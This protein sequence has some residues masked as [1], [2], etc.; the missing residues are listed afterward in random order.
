MALMNR[1][2]FLGLAIVGL[3]LVPGVSFGDEPKK[4]ASSTSNLEEETLKEFAELYVSKFLPAQKDP[5]ATNILYPGSGSDLQ[6]LHLGL[7]LLKNSPMERVRYVYTEIG[8]AVDKE[9]TVSWYNH[10]EDLLSAF[11]QELA[12]FVSRGLLT[13]P[14]RKILAEHPWRVP[15]IPQSTVIEYSFM[16]PVG[17][18]KKELSLVL[19][20]N[21]FE[22]RPELTDSEKEYFSSE[23]LAKV[24]ANYWP[25]KP[26]AGAI[27]PKYARD[28][29][30]SAAD[31]ILSHQCGDF[32]LLMF[33]YLRALLNP[34][35]EKK[36][37]IILTEHPEKNYALTKPPI[38][39]NCGV[40]FL[41]HN[42]YGYV[43]GEGKVGAV[44]FTPNYTR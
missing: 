17:S 41:K 40:E 14:Q 27:Y 5:R 6:Q 13:N 12:P 29:Q 19:S 20:Y 3:G 24:R 42:H 37:K 36:Q 33:D 32:D 22:E 25:V 2:H 10:S 8:E 38:G 35:T 30:F 7:S 18:G 16:V 15:N 4:N 28:D 39:Y 34:S 43:K 23:F 11:D 21:A 1:K 26:K 44:I 9:G 31:I